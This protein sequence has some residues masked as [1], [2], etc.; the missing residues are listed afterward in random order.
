MQF[1][2]KFEFCSLE[3][4]SSELA[5]HLWHPKDLELHPFVVAAAKA[6]LELHISQQCLLA[7]EDERQHSTFSC[8]FLYH[9]EEVVIINAFQESHRIAPAITQIYMKASKIDIDFD[10]QYLNFI[11]AGSY[12]AVQLKDIFDCPRQ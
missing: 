7:G 12:L 6:A 8:G 5:A 1:P 3:V 4:Q 10:L 11:L 9:L 2:E